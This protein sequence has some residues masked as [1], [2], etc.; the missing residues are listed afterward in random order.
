[1]AI[2]VKSLTT[3]EDNPLHLTGTTPSETTTFHLKAC[4]RIQFPTLKDANG[5]LLYHRPSSRSFFYRTVAHRI[6]GQLMETQI[7]TIRQLYLVY[8]NALE[9]HWFSHQMELW[10][11]SGFQSSQYATATPNLE[12]HI[13]LTQEKHGN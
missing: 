6:R 12:V 5:N 1:M 4:L 2:I 7:H 9:D 11:G 10:K 8:H 3:L 13:S